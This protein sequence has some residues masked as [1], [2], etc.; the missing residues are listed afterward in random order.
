M[1]T[2][3]AHNAGIVIATRVPSGAFSCLAFAAARVRLSKRPR[4][5][6]QDLGL[7]S[8]RIQQGRQVVLLV[9]VP[10]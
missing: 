2:A 8:T 9:G 1:S 7:I 5:K 6:Y 4:P 10:C 3:F